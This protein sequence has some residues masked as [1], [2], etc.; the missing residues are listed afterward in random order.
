[1][2]PFMG[3]V[4]RVMNFMEGQ[5][6]ITWMVAWVQTTWTADQVM[7]RTSLTMRGTSSLSGLT[8]ELIL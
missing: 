8:T 3:W 6:M 2:T 1:M 5:A 4:I 7:I